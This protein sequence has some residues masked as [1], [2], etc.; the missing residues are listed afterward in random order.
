M[1][2]R[3]KDKVSFLV[4]YGR[5]AHPRGAHQPKENVTEG[6]SIPEHKTL[7]DRLRQA[8][9]LAQRLRVPIPVVV[10]TMDNAAMT[11]FQALPDRLFIL[12]QEGSIAF[13]TKKGPIRFKVEDVSPI[14]DRLLERS[15]EK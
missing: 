15:L 6:I 2:N 4:V 13:L 8:R 1:F 12:T 14:L 10:D 9:I 3:Y 11:A 5:E 7:A